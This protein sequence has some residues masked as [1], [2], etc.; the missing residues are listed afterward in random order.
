MQSATVDEDDYFHYGVSYWNT[1][2]VLTAIS[3]QEYFISQIAIC[4]EKA[5]IEK[6]L[7]IFGHHH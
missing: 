6:Q 5:C 3:Q 7:H 4:P 1:R 2:M